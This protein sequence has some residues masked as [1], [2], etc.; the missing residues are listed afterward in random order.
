MAVFIV[1]NTGDSGARSLRQAILNANTTAG[2][3]QINFNI[4]PGGLQ[5]ISPATPLPTI[6][7]SLKIDGTTQ[8]GYG[9]TPI[10]D[11]KGP[12]G[13]GDGL[14]LSG[15]DCTIRGLAIGGFRV[16]GI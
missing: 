6:T 14:H 4:A 16:N 10:I 9:G 1:T 11:L 3:D 13:I 2:A 15:P 12:A 8:P 7:E 5:A